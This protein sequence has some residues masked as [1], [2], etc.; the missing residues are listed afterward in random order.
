MVQACPAGQCG[1]PQPLA[2]WGRGR[3]AGVAVAGTGSAAVVSARDG[4]DE[5]LTAPASLGVL[6]RALDRVIGLGHTQLV[7][8]TLVLA[9]GRHPVTELGVSAFPSS[10]TE[11]V[12]DAARA[13]RCLG[14]VAA[15]AAGLQV[16]VVDTG[17]ATGND[18]DHDH[19]P[20]TVTVTEQLLQQGED[21]GAVLGAA[22]VVA[23]GEVD[24][25]NTT[26]AAGLA[27]SLLRLDADQVVGLGSGA[28]TAM[29]DR[30][31]EVVAAALNRW[32]ANP[33][34]HHDGVLPAQRLAA[35]GGP[36]FALLVGVVRGAAH[37]G[38]VIMLDG[39]ATSVAAL[40]AVQAEP[41]VAAHL[42]AG[43]RSR[44]PAHPAVLQ[45][46]GLQPLLDYGCAPGKASGPPWVPSCCV[47]DCN[48]GP[49]PPAPRPHRGRA[50]RNPRSR[51][52]GLACVGGGS[53]RVP[54]TH[55]GFAYR[56]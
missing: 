45:R 49:A 38:A 41:A 10:V 13:G 43:Q 17:S 31:T 47:P 11:D 30:K 6:D 35:L 12:L 36:E 24:I 48:C 27:S 7:G 8:G 40:I 52:A 19:D 56:S 22:G 1:D 25:G 37:A 15:T 26:V 9:V 46:L 4:A 34:A 29:L 33:A 42:V 32:T 50:A 28:D 23:L 5:L 3:S 16:R 18:H 44:E 53:R 39:L 55:G 54:V 21:L 20:M 14:A 2:R 51:A